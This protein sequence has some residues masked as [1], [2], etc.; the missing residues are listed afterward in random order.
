MTLLPDCLTAL[1]AK[2][3]YPRNLILEVGSLCENSTV[4]ISLIVTLPK[5]PLLLFSL[6]KTTF[7][8]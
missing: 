5:L 4:P 1:I 2:E 8:T 3:G 6:I 7:L